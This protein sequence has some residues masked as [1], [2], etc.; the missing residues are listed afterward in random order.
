MEDRKVILFIA[1][2]LDGYI[3]K[4]NGDIN[5]LSIVDNPPEDYG[6]KEFLSNVD[7]VIMGRKTYEKVLSFGID[8]PHKD[9]KCY[10][11]SE[12][13]VGMDENVE[14][15]SRNLKD[16]ISELRNS[17]GKNIF[18][19]GGAEIVNE[20]LKLN[21]IDEY[22]ISI[23]PVLLGSGIRL[24]NNERPECMLKLKSV[25]GYKTGLVKVWY[26]NK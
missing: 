11:A 9:K 20:L 12:T 10:V 13:K 5:W 21:C 17:D 15:C 18:I 2:S 7:T 8:F 26:E 1:M 23:V 24:F 22:I 3:A 6:Y 19:D 14:Y 25:T 16:L 4:A